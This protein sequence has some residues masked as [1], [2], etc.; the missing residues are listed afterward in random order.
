MHLVFNI[1][2]YLHDNSEYSQEDCVLLSES[3]SVNR[4]TESIKKNGLVFFTGL[5]P[6]KVGKL[7]VES[8]LALRWI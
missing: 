4:F 7:E 6:E 5:S 3:N 1:F 8:F 2:L